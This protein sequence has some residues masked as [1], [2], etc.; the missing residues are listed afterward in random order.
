M[1]LAQDLAEV[2][3][4]PHDPPPPKRVML[5]GLDWRQ[6]G[7]LAAGLHEAGIETFLLTTGLADH[8]G[9]GRYCEHVRTPKY[10]SP[11]YVP[12]LRAEIARLRPDLL[13]PLCE[14]LIELLWGLDRLPAPIYPPTEAWQ[15]KVVFDRRLLYRRAQSAGVPIPPWLP[16]SGPSDLDHAAGKFGFPLVIRGTAGFGGN[17]VRIVHSRDAAC[18]ALEQIRKISP[19]QPFAQAFVRGGRYLFGGVFHQGEMIR[20]FSHR[21]LE[22]HPAITG[23]AIRIRPIREPRLAAHGEAIFRDLQWSGIAFAEFI[24]SEA[25]E[26][27]LMEINVRPWG[28][29]EIAEK[30]GAQISRTFGEMLLGHAITAQAPYP[31]GADWLI[32][33]GYLLSRRQTG[34]WATLR[35]LPPVDIWMCL[36]AVP[37]SRPRLAFHVMRRTYRFL[38][39]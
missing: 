5:L 9:L 28:S 6:N 15:R 23:P 2:P 25:G 38:W 33:E 13:I 37:W 35:R 34:V 17:Q 32:L 22:T 1:R 18:T 11:E 14:P 30:C 12:F 4:V 20:S 3:I 27:V 8:F 31:V 19:E 24:Q 10:P 39:G 16:L 36:K 29:L 26:F 7:H 21:T